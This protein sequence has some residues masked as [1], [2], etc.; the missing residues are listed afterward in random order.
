[1]EHARM[2]PSA[3]LVALEMAPLVLPP[4]EVDIGEEEVPVDDVVLLLLEEAEEGDEEDCNTHPI[5]PAT[6]PR[7]RSSA[8]VELSCPKLVYHDLPLPPET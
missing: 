5:P 2:T 6:W 7:K 3:D 8:H 1:M 4:V